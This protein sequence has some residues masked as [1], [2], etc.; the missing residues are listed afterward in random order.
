MLGVCAVTAAAVA[1]AVAAA[2]GPSH[3]R[4]APRTAAAAANSALFATV[5][6]LNERKPAPQD[7]SVSSAPCVRGCTIPVAAEVRSPTGQTT[8]CASAAR[9]A[10]CV[11]PV[12]AGAAYCSGG[13]APLF[14][15]DLRAP[16]RRR[17]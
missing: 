12:A 11:E 17:R 15:R 9:S 2:P 5:R 6:R 10:P 7:C 3:H 16:S 13:A 4:A 1:L 8:P 14:E